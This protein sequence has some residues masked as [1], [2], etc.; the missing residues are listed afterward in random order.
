MNYESIYLCL[1]ESVTVALLQLLWETTNLGYQGVHMD[2]QAEKLK[3]HSNEWL[4]G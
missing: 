3:C 4:F 2:K 1:A